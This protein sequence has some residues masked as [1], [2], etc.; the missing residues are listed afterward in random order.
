VQHLEGKNVCPDGN[1]ELGTGERVITRETLDAVSTRE[2]FDAE[3][4]AKRT[5]D[6]PALG[7]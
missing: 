4:Q 5:I 3:L 2:L 6:T 1:K 7:K